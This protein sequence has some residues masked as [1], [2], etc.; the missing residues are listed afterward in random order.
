MCRRLDGI[1]LAIELATARI[2]ALAVEQI[3]E[4]LQDS[5]KL[6]TGGSRTATPRQRTLRGTLDWSYD[7]LSEA[8]K[9]L[10]GRLSV[11]A[12]GWT[13]EA[14]EAVGAGHGI[15]RDDV[16]D[17][18][19]DLV[20]KSLVQAEAGGDA[21]R[22]RMLEP[23]RQYA[24]ERLEERGK[25]GRSGTGIRPSSWHS[26][27][28]WSRSSEERG[29]RRGWSAS[30]ASTTTSERL[31]NGR[32]RAERASRDYGSAVRWETSGTCADT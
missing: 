27:R 7:L 30:S 14:A 24:L 1:P 11:F 13:L 29:K 10:F 28:R 26:R 25:R 19:N 8:E 5:L 21:L 32:S 16:L 3:A 2:T 23:V 12:G 4:R 6:L 18:L 15:G 22:Y 31:S 9:K 20:D 17:L